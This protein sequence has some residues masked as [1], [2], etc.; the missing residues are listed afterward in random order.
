MVKRTEE[1]KTEERKDLNDQKKEI[2]KTWEDSYTAISKIWGDSLT[3]YRPLLESTGE[4]FGKSFELSK[5]AAPEKYKEF[6]DQWVKIYQDSSGKLYQIPGLESNKETFE[7]LLVSAEESNK[8]YRSWIDELEENSRVTREVLQ[9]EPDPVKYKEVYDLW[10]KS[11]GKVFDELLTLPFRQNI[12]DLFENLTGTPDVYSDTIEQISKQ[13]KASYAKLY[14]PWIGSILKLS[15]KSEDISRGNANPEVYKEFY[16]LWLDTYQET[17]AKSFG[18]Q[19]DHISK[20]IFESFVQSVNINLNLNRSW[21]VTLEKLSYRARDLSKQTS[22]PEAYTEFYN[23]WA[24][25]YGKA[26][27]N[28]FENTP[29]ISPFKEIMEPV[30]NAAKIYTDTFTSISGVK[31]HPIPVSAV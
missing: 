12:K 25:T 9:G 5:D 4:L 27:D 28:F 11:Y 14:S 6:Y 16:T 1:R 26:I 7:K 17:Y 31:S 15:A 3:L 19:S 13:W 29:T 2:F 10:I 22:D 18:I 8:I 23:L 30:K 20:E 24:K 21:I